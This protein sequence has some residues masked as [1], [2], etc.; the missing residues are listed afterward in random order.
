M[1]V[2]LN[3]YVLPSAITLVALGTSLPDTFA[4]RSAAVMDPDADASIMNVTGS[5]AVNVLL[6]LG[7]PWFLGALYCKRF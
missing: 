5:N 6:G 3:T 1:R 2:T 4:S 7:L